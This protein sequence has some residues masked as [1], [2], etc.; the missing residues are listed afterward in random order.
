MPQEPEYISVKDTALRLN[1]SVDHVYD[2]I[3]R[4]RL[5]ALVEGRTKSVRIASL[6]RYITGA[7]QHAY[8]PS[9]GQAIVHSPASSSQA[10]QK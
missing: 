10:S 6:E 5:E 8:D 9:T 1:K 2:L 7:T 4:R 3:A